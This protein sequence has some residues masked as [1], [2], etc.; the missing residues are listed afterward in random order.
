M[1]RKRTL[2]VKKSTILLCSDYTYTEYLGILYD[3]VRS[4][5][6]A[7][8][9]VAFSD[10][11]MEAHRIDELKKMEELK[12]K[13]S[14]YIHDI[15]DLENKELTS[16]IYRFKSQMDKIKIDVIM[17][18]EIFANNTTKTYVLI[19]EHYYITLPEDEIYLMDGWEVACI[20]TNP[21]TE[22]AR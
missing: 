19:R 11:E 2:A 18:M 15:I 3:R 1:K 20:I 5:R 14:A 12:E 21:F 4:F 9:V 7:S 17:G 8:Q 13:Y 16:F 22:N 6:A 10:E